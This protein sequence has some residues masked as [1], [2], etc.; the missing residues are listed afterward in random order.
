MGP[1]PVAKN[2]EAFYEWALEN[3]YPPIGFYS[4]YPGLG[5][6]DIRAL[7]ADHRSRST[8]A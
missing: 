1:H 3:N 8:S 7:L 5:V 2:A 6:T 4:G